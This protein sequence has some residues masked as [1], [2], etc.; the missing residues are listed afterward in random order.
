MLFQQAPVLFRRLG[1]KRGIA[2]A[3]PPRRAEPPTGSPCRSPSVTWRAA[4]RPGK[5][6][7]ARRD[8]CEKGWQSPAMPGTSQASAITCSGWRRWP[9]S[10]K[11]PTAPSACWPPRMRCCKPRAPAGWWPTQRRRRPTMTPCPDCAAG[12]ETQRSSRPGPMAP[13][14]DASGPWSTRYKN[15]DGRSVWPSSNCARAVTASAR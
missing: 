10:G 13:P 7:P 11:T 2:I 9:G 1:D 4:A 15:D 12:W 5:T 3:R 8:S 6:W 14:W